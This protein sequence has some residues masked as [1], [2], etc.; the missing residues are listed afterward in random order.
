MGVLGCLADGCGLRVL[1][2]L[3]LDRVG[4]CGGFGA[5]SGSLGFALVLICDVV[6]CVYCDFAAWVFR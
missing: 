3:V 1:K 4:G 6:T 2:L 5:S